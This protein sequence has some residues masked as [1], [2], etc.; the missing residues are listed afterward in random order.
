MVTGWGS[1]LFDCDIFNLFCI[2]T[3]EIRNMKLFSFTPGAISWFLN[4]FV[5]FKLS[6]SILHFLSSLTSLFLSRFLFL[7][8]FFQSFCFVCLLL[9]PELKVWHRKC[10]KNVFLCLSTKLIYCQKF[11]ES[12]H[13]NL[14]IFL[15]LGVRCEPFNWLVRLLIC[16]NLLED[17]RLRIKVLSTIKQVWS[18]LGRLGL[19]I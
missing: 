7:F 13:L 5:F 17:F 9:K 10:R 18:L 1:W 3:F 8:L 6:L 4:I 11:F 12:I 14:S 19:V 15:N 16:Q 2:V